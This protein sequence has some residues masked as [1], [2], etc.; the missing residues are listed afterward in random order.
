[1]DYIRPIISKYN[2]TEKSFFT[3]IYA[4]SLKHMMEIGRFLGEKHLSSYLKKKKEISTF[5]K[6]FQRKDKTIVF[7]L[8]HKLFVLSK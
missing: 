1:M 6:K 8:R 3:R 2:F 5:F 7:P 4:K